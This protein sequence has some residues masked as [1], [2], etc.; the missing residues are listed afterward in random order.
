[1]AQELAM[2]NV[3][4][5][6]SDGFIGKALTSRLVSKGINVF[7]FDK[8]EGDISVNNALESYRQKGISHI[9]HLAG[10]TFVPESW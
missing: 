8:G 4:I 9:F 10:K 5:T 1:M 2:N 3:L 7:G 6:G